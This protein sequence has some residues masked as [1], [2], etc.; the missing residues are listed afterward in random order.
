MHLVTF[1]TFIRDDIDQLY[2]NI[3][4]LQKEQRKQIR[5]QFDKI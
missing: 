3:S 4:Y 2:Q 5:Y 1:V